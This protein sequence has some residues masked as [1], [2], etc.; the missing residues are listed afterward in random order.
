M[1]TLL[2]KS[3]SEYQHDDENLNYLIHNFII[4]WNARGASFCNCLL[5]MS[6]QMNEMIRNELKSERPSDPDFIQD[7]NKLHEKI[8]QQTGSESD[9]NHS[10]KLH[11]CLDQEHLLVFM[12]MKQKELLRI[13]NMET[14]HWTQ[15]INFRRRKRG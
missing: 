13:N 10:S 5:T 9:G 4:V 6:R 11:L 8:K 2:Q 1:Q 3:H 15:H 14:R 12:K 7:V